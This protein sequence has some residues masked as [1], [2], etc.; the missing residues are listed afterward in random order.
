M[1]FGVSGF[2]FSI[3][4]WEWGSGVWGWKI[5]VRGLGVREWDFGW[6]SRVLAAPPGA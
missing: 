6:G 1:M 4:V 5:G 2:M 3:G